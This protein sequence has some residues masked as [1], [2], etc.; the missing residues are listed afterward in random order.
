[1]K[2]ITIKKSTVAQY[3]GVGMNVDFMAERFG[4]TTKEMNSVLETFGMRKGRSKAE[5]AYVINAVDDMA[6]TLID[7]S[8]STT[9]AVEAAV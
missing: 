2:T 9:A 6:D 4:V 3:R 1:M 8:E 5:P 7:A